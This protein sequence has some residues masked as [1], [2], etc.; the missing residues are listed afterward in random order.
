M[1]RRRKRTPWLRNRNRSAVTAL[2]VPAR[3][4]HPRRIFRGWWIVL[5]GLLALVINGG[6][7]SFVFSVLIKPMEADLGWSRTTLVGVITM[8][9]IVSG[10]LAAPTGLLVDR[11]GSRVLTTAGAAVSGVAFLLVSRMNSPLQYYLLLGLLDAA[12]RPALD[13]VGPRTAIANWFVRKRPAAF[14]TYSIG[15]ALAGLFLVPPLAILTGVQGWRAVWVVMGLLHFLVLVPISWF[16]IRKRPED[17]GQLPD[18]DTLQAPATPLDV[19]PPATA[20]RAEPEWT[21]RAAL[22]TREFWAVAAGVFLVSVPGATIY[23]HM[24]AYFQDRGL[25]APEAAAALS[26]YAFGAL[27]GRLVWAMVLAKVGVQRALVAFAFVYGTGIVALVLT[28]GLALFLVV[29]ILG[30]AIG[31]AAQLQAQVWPDYFGRRAV[32]TLVGYSALITTPAMAGGPLVAAFLYDTT[33]S[34]TFIFGLFAVFS[35]VAGGCFL[36]A[37]R[38]TPPAFA[39][40]P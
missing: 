40:A 9:A 11:Y 21:A 10:L 31:G 20:V 35:Y 15:R 6:A 28:Q 29:L 16:A 26:M 7:T 36:L 18:G 8:T 34:Y 1:P 3:L 2:P 17:E 27:S 32:G 30:L 33:G 25:S 37:R 23:I 19:P 4:P 24:V 38:P 13:T 39:T 22:R 5:A 12:S 14:A